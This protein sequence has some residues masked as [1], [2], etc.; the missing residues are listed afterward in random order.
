MRLYFTGITSVEDARKAVAWGAA[1]IGIKMGYQ[2]RDVHPEKAREIFL[3]LPVFVSRVGI[4]ANEKRYAI[5]ELI[6]FCRLDTL[7]FIGNEQPQDVARFQEHVLKTFKEEE[8]ASIADYPVEGIVLHGKT[9]TLFQEKPTLFQE[10]LCIL[11][12]LR[13]EKEWCAAV[14]SCRPFALQLDL[15]DLNDETIEKLLKLS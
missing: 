7:H 13:S 8:F 12:G 3:K 5:Q 4:F 14:K 2:E 6:T 9:H 10:K 1:A 11:T 15:S